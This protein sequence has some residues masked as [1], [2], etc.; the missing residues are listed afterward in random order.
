MASINPAS[1][2]LALLAPGLMVA[3]YAQAAE[4]PETEG[5]FKVAKIYF[6]TNASACDMGIQIVFDTDGIAEGEFKDPHGRIIHAIR[7]AHGLHA[8]GGQTEGFLESVEPVI[9]DLVKANRRCKPDPDEP[10]A[11]LDEIR[12]M[13]PP[14]PYDFEGEAADG[15]ALKDKDALTYDIP[16]GP[17]LGSPDGRVG[18]NPDAPVKI[19]W[20]PVTLTIPGLLPNRQQR[21][22]TIT[23][24]QVLVYDANAGEAP[25]EFNVT[26]PPSETSVTVPV[27]FLL[28][29]TEYK[30]E[31]LAIE[32]S[33]NQTIT[34]GT[35]STR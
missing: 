12:Q 2:T 25:P 20:K 5:P 23:G 1:P 16:D 28:P 22:V 9:T 34:E 26:V 21:P 6:E 18:V 19:T 35:F 11:T 27:Q 4:P 8:V 29:G 13:F 3:H 7:A 32:K 17:D 30:I 31:V 15:T 33:G 14:G 10:R 24:Y